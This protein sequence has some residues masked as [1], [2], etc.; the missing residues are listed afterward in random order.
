MADVLNTTLAAGASSSELSVT[1]LAPLAFN[2][3]KPCEVLAKNTADSGASWG[4]IYQS[5]DGDD[6]RIIYPTSATIKVKAGSV[7]AR[8]LIVDG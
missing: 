5:R 6:T 7:A 2:S 1:P 8:V 4:V 3:S